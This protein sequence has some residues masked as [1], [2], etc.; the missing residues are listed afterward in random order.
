MQS[1]WAIGY[2]LA[3]LVTWLL[4]DTYGWR[5]VFFVG[6]GYLE[7]S[8]A[9]GN[10]A[11]DRS[12]AGVALWPQVRHPDA[13][14]ASLE[15]AAP[16]VEAPVTKPWGLR[17]ARLLDPDGLLLVFVEIPAA[18]PLRRDSRQGPSRGDRAD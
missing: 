4:V 14:F 16:V 13:V 17:E 6:G 2:A 3:A 9:D 5:V 7:L 12:R 15:Q 10:E 11:A 18:H 8:H 1:A